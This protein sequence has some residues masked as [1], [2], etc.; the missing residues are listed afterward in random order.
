[1][2]RT[3]RGLADSSSASGSGALL[4]FEHWSSAAAAYSTSSANR[5]GRMRPV[6]GVPTQRRRARRPAASSWTGVFPKLG[7][8]PSCGM[9]SV[10][11]LKCVHFSTCTN[12]G[13]TAT[14]RA[15]LTQRPQSAFYLMKNEV[16]SSP[17]VPTIGP[18]TQ[19][20]HTWEL[21][22]SSA[23]LSD[24]HAQTGRGPPDARSGTLSNA[25]CIE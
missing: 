15:N 5:Q 9:W 10:E 14:T 2:K 11:S 23:E 21:K 1:M 19:M 7:V 24:S 6:P 16:Q 20:N 8:A 4:V 18:P 22:R 17:V 12:P 25:S 13:P 3:T